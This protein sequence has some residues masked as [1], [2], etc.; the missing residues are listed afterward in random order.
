M[1]AEFSAVSTGGRGEGPQRPAAPVGEAKA[2][3]EG[4]GG[5]A[6]GST[7]NAS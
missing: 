3:S 7:A 5:L 2:P 4:P 6:A 1:G